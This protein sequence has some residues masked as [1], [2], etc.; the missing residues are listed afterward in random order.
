MGLMHHRPDERVDVF[1]FQWFDP[2]LG[3]TVLTDFK[4]TADIIRERFHGQVLS[5]TRES[6]AADEVSDDGCWRRAAT[7]WCQGALPAD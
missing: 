3:A 1:T 2:A 5:L 6:V 4:A 7:G